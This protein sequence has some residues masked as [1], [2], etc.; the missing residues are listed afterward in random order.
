MT[1]L[2]GEVEGLDA[3][4]SE[5]AARWDFDVAAPF[6]A[7]LVGLDGGVKARTTE[8][9]DP[10]AWF[11]RIDAMPMRRAELRERASD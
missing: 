4:V 8:A 7:L 9:V 6:A 1:V 3:T 5:L 10:D 2:A 11:A